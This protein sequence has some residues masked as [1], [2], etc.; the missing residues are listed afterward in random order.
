MKRLK[1]RCGEGEPARA[2]TPFESRVAEAIR[3]IPRG[4]TLS[5]SG[6]A[7]EAGKPGAA[8]A[9]VRAMKNLSDIPWW[10]VIRRDGTLAAEVA[11]EQARRLRRE[12]V[13][14]EGRRVLRTE[15]MKKA[16]AQRAR[17]R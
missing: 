17:T 10:R 14:V 5:Y 2:L 11:F 3:A 4:T 9:V 13:P 16:R 8:R 6:V 12:G 15:P 1:Q 7:L